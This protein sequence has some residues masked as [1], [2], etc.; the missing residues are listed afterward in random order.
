MLKI[1]YEG[2]VFKSVNS[3][4]NG[5][6]NSE[7]TFYYHQKDDVVWA[8][9]VGGDILKGMLIAKVDNYGNLNMRYHHIDSSGEIMTGKCLSKPEILKDKKIRLVETW[10]WTSGDYSKGNSVIEEVTWVDRKIEVKDNSKFV[11]ATEGDEHTIY[12][13]V[14][15]TISEIYPNYY[16]DDVVNF[17][18]NHHTLENIKIAL[19]KET[20]ILVK[21]N[22]NMVG[23]GALLG[24]EIRRMFILPKFQGKGYARAL[25]SRLESEAIA[26]GYTEVFLDSSLSAFS[27]YDKNGYSSVKYE[28]LVTPKGQVLCY[29]RMLKELYL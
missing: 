11:V 12:G 28:K 20:I 19:N 26:K 7:T 5:Q 24:N 1:N 21:D 2:R 13:I 23:T 9:Y 8:E 18:L 3:T 22:E 29:N 17:F 4:E 6:V 16:P 15:S 10:E 27:L 25:L 14:Q